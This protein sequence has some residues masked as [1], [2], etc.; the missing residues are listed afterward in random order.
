[1]CNVVTQNR[2]YPPQMKNG[3]KILI[4]ED[5][6][7]SRTLLSGMLSDFGSCVIA[8]DGNQAVEILEYS[9]R[10]DERFDLVCLDIVMPELSGQEVL[11]AMRNMERKLGIDGDRATKVIMTTVLGDSINIMQAF[12]QGNCEAYLTKPIDKVQLIQ[13]LQDLKLIA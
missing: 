2:G 6:Y 5:E 9:F 10:S 12:K 4:V 11:R 13:L 1:M 7:I 8:A 3:L